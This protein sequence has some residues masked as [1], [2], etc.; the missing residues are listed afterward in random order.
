MTT[1]SNSQGNGSPEEP[2]GQGGGEPKFVTADDLNKAITAR[3]SAFEKKNATTLE[4]TLKTFGEGVFA[5]LEELKPK[6]IEP[7]D[8]SNEPPKIDDHPVVKGLQK[9]LAELAKTNEQATQRAAAERARSRDSQL[10][11]KLAEE[12]M[13]SGFKDA[14]QA[15]HA[16]HFLADGDK[17]VRWA[18]EDSDAIVFRD[19]D[20]TEVDLAT[21]LKGWAKT[22][23][24][25][26]YLPP[27]GASGSGDRGGGRSPQGGKKKP[28]RGELG[29]ALA[30]T[31]GSGMVLRLGGGPAK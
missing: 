6:P 18:D 7:G 4:A 2:Q 21:G 5:K 16:V 31:I 29:A 10:R 8:K 27:Q 26:I 3:F 14:N 24:A 17:R 25:K 11:S 20:G 30:E 22:D 15:R 19:N 12:L 28:Q 9:Q 23:D 1:G 13:K